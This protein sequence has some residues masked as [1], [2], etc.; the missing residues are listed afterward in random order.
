MELR[1]P[2]GEIGACHPKLT[3][4]DVAWRS[5]SKQ[6][7]RKR[8]ASGKGASF[9]GNP[10]DRLTSTSI[11]PYSDG[12]AGKRSLEWSHDDDQPRPKSHMLDMYATLLLY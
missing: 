7:A 1:P 5:N 10:F 2:D 6:G 12:G 11:R 8:Q 9:C 4:C 3:K